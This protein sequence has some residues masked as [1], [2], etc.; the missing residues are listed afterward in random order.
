MLINLAVE[1]LPGPSDLR[2]KKVVGANKLL[3]L[4]ARDENGQWSTAL[5]PF[6]A[7]SWGVLRKYGVSPPRGFWLAL[8]W[9]PVVR[10]LLEFSRVNGG[11]PY[12]FGAASKV[13]SRPWRLRQEALEAGY[14]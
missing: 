9:H 8:P 12:R 2:L 11:D 5:L 3:A 14:R 6:P 1:Y 13:A 4:Q 10:R 7:L